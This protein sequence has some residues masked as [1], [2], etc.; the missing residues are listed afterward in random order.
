MQMLQR[1]SDTVDVADVARS[2]GRQWR[3]VIA[4]VAIGF[5]GA[6]AV[7]LFAPKRYE[8]KATVLART[9]AQGGGSILSRI[10]GLEGLMGGVGGGALGASGMETELQLLKSESLGAQV[11][12]SLKLQ[13]RVK[14]PAGVAP[15]GLVQAYDLR[16]SFATRAYT[17]E[18]SAD[19]SY[20][21]SGDSVARI[22]RPG[23]TATLDV[24]SITLAASGLPARFTVRLMDR[25]DALDRFARRLS[26]SKAGGEIAKVVYT[27]DDRQTAADAPNALIAF[28]LQ[29]RT[30]IDRGANQR[31]VEYVTDQLQQTEAQLTTAE[32]ELRKYQEQT[33]VFDPM[34]L[35]KAQVENYGK[36]RTDLAALEIDEASVK[37]LLQLADSGT[38]TSQDLIAYPAF[39]RGGALTP[40]AT[41][42]SD[43]E[44]E[45]TRL[46]E[47]RTEKDPEVQAIDRSIA[48]VNHSI[49]AMTRTYATA[50]AKQRSE[51]EARVD[52]AEQ[53][54]KL[55]PAASERVG[56]LQRDVIR[57]TALATALQ[58]QLVEARL[59]A[60]GEGGDV[61]QVDVSDAPREPSFPKPLF[62]MGLGTAGGLFAGVVAALFLGWF[63]RW[64][65][66]PVEIERLTGITAER[67]QAD[68]PLLVAGAAVPRTVLV[69]PLDARAQS[70]GVAERL[71]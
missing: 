51:Y 36:M 44:V 32:S 28:Y 53:T 22:A 57:L 64:L 55:L 11:M 45:R 9:G 62:T 46:L 48:T 49:A 7:V 54:L 67:F 34:I 1:E 38:L 39:T 60:I 12:D 59:G 47:R 18:R 20:R 42:L 27:A 15:S 52:S 21:V 16:P 68:A 43:L 70:R 19:G 31:R 69:V 8:G 25:E 3:A 50:V 56:R 23:Q 40:F 4:F 71:A 17:F 37:H 58:A 65:R 14:E 5:L 13:V 29:R 61:R 66:D 63:G 41:Q 6:L 10:G 33:G 24:G 35:D 30:T 2:L 26:V